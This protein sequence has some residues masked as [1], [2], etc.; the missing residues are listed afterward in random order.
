MRRGLERTLDECLS[1]L[2]TGELGLEEALARYPEYEA[3]L[4]P[5]LRMAMLVRQTPRAVPSPAAKAAG[6]QRL[7]AAVARKKREKAQARPGLARRLGQSVAV[8]VQPWVQPQRQPLRLAQAIAAVLVV[9]SLISAG[10]VKVA[11]SSLPNSPLYTIKRATERVQLALTTTAAGRARLHMDYSEKRLEE[12]QTLWEAGKGLHEMTL[13]AIESEYSGALTAISQVP[14]EERRG[15]LGDFTLLTARQQVILEEMKPEILPS[16]Q[17]A[18][19]EALETSAEY[20][21]LAMEAMT[22]PDRLLTPTVASG[23]SSLLAAPE[24][25]TDTPVP[26][27]FTPSPVPTDTPVPPTF[28][29]S[30]V[31][32]ATPVPP[33]FTPSPVPTATPVP[34]TFTPIPVPTETPPADVPFQPTMEPTPTETPPADVPFQPAT[35]EP[36][37]PTPT[38]T[39]TPTSTPVP[40]TSTPTSTPVPP[41]STPT[42]TPVP[43]TSTP[44]STPVPPT[45]TPV[46]PTSTPTAQAV[47]PFQ[48]VPASLVTNC[49]VS[50]APQGAAVATFPAGTAKVY[51]VFDYAYMA[52]EEVGIRVYDNSG[53]VLFEATRT[54]DGEGTVSI[55]FAVGGGGFAPGRYLVNIY[56]AGGVIR[57]MIWDV[58]ET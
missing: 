26:P 18:V 57:T 6:R 1:Q 5:L 58:A 49:R 36:I 37:E 30:P 44:T 12:A 10:T 43:P 19:E 47:A 8:L 51:I 38:P 16:D 45:S 40:P 33:T 9:V 55:S 41:T 17:E 25:P 3:E 21:S 20:Q 15:L 23:D 7:L 31:P 4:R 22:K 42:S 32:T 46:P 14:E 2:N 11:A 35:V 50:D 29:P 24:P 56:R 53:H 48:P 54:L 52:G 28:T 13:W 34:P 39:S 27:T